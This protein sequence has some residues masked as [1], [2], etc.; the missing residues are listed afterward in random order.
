MRAA[1]T[2]L[3]TTA[4]H[5]A[6]LD[7]P[8]AITS[9]LEDRLVALSAVYR[10]AGESTSNTRCSF[11]DLVSDWKLLYRNDITVS[12]EI[13]ELEIAPDERSMLDTLIG[14]MLDRRGAV[15]VEINGPSM[16]AIPDSGDP[17]AAMPELVELFADLTISVEVYMQATALHVRL[18]KAVRDDDG[19]VVT[20][21]KGALTAEPSS[22]YSSIANALH[23]MKNQIA[24][25]R[26]SG[27]I[28]AGLSRTDRLHRELIASQ[29]LDRA[30]LLATQ[31]QAAGSLATA[32]T[33]TTEL[34]A[35][36]R[37]YGADLLRRLPAK[38]RIAV[39]SPATPVTVELDNAHLAAILDN[40]VKNALEALP[41]GGTVDL[42]ATGD[43]V[44]AYI[45]VSDDGPGVPGHII[46]AVSAGRAIQSTKLN[47]NGLG[48]L[49]IRNL[50]CRVGGSLTYISDHPG[51]CWRIT[52]PL[53]HD[54]V[55]KVNET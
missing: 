23:D 26:Q 14:R 5:L 4:Q 1:T 11:T 43:T 7:E 49:G 50:V 46:D 40:L 2:A 55:T 24:A 30:K 51:A 21:V 12:G 34:S 13:P 48:L 20:A 3:T 9:E 25:A 29:H 35:Y 8:A 47:G 53:A 45:E 37:S 32:S 41:D 27:N 54:V 22:L 10:A 36:L 31:L 6:H 33:G 16:R 42:S 39:N 28:P 15:H 44:D 19:P 18:L 38:L 17:D 52:L